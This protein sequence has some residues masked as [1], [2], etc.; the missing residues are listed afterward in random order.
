MCSLGCFPRE[1][2]F[3]PCRHPD[4]FLVALAR[5][6]SGLRHLIPGARCRTP[7][8]S[9]PAGR[10]VFD[11][12]LGR[13]HGALGSFLWKA[14]S[15]GIVKPVARNRF[16]RLG[17]DDCVV[18]PRLVAFRRGRQQLGSFRCLGRRTLGPVCGDLRPFGGI[19]RGFD[20][21][22]G[23]K[24]CLARGRLRQSA[25]TQRQPLPTL[26]PPYPVQRHASRRAAR[27]RSDDQRPCPSPREWC[28]PLSPSLTEWYRSRDSNSNALAGR[29]V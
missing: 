18:R 15:L 3:F 6:T 12:C 14:L 20:G 28:P 2:Q 9:E 4:G 16:G 5:D 10:Q 27:L 19:Q 1:P 24:G 7:F 25:T 29:G 8:C 13:V 22:L 26:P 17:I 21:R 11:V 23:F